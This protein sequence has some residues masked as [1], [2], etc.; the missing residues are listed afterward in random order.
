MQHSKKALLEALEQSMGVVTT[1]CRALGIDRTAHYRY[2][3]N[4]PEYKAAVE[5][6]ENVALD[7]AESELHKN[8]IKGD[9]TAQIFYLKTKGRKRGY[10][11]KH[12][13]E[14]SGNVTV[15]RVVEPEPDALD[16]EIIG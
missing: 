14:H 12:D 4:D 9:T 6:I 1:A 5:E 15:T 11:E 10:I 16:A 13:V 8:I 3:A 7:I 2:M